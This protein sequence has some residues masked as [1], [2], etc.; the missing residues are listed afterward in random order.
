MHYLSHRCRRAVGWLL[1]PSLIGVLPLARAAGTVDAGPPTDLSVTVYRA[2]YDQSGSLDLG[3]LR[4][5]ALISERRS[6][7]IPAGESLVRFPG[8]ADGMRASTAVLAGMPG[9]LLEMNRDARVLSPLELIRAAV[10][11][12]V[13]LV[14]TNPRTGEVTRTPATIQAGD[15]GSVV[16]ATAQGV[17]AL[18]CSGLDEHFV[19]SSA[20]ESAAT[21]TLSMRVRMATPLNA[22]VTLSYLA[23]GFDWRADYVATLSADAG[24]MSLGGWVTLANSN[25]AGFPAAHA[26][27]VAGRLNRVAEDDQPN[28]H[29]EQPIAQCWPSDN[30]SAQSQLQGP[31][32]TPAPKAAEF[33]Q[34]VV[35]TTRRAEGFAA[36]PAAV[37]VQQE[38]LGDLKLYRVPETTD[39]ASHQMK[40]VRL[41]DRQ[42][43]RVARFYRADLYANAGDSYEPARK[44]LR[45]R[46]DDAHHLGLALPAGQVAATIIRD[47][48][49]LLLS[50]SPIPD[51]ARDEVLEIDLG[52]SADVQLHAHASRIDVTNAQSQAADLEIHLHIPDGMQLIAARP[53]PAQA[54]AQPLFKVTVPAHGSASVRYQTEP[55]SR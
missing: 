38:Q 19:F 32:Q 47:G 6:I 15:Q 44:M 3:Y 24:T 14:R 1:V 5:Y 34:M 41:L 21:P 45:T 20:G 50:E 27:V 16:F 23:D 17:E 37:M 33:D 39:V 52:D 9:E 49:P 12:Q 8:V 22:S 11:T 30:T 18:H 35:V 26:Q 25:T 40:Q 2:P 36:A 43:I 28:D 55:A 29:Q 31:M 13:A 48:E 4:G 51:T 42:G 54:G 53:A 46:N 10:G 7:S